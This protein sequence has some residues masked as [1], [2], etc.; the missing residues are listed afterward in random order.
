[1][2]KKNISQ[3]YLVK[4]YFLA[5]PMRDIPHAEIVDWL[6]NE[7][8]LRNDSIFRDPD[9]AIRSLHQSGF[10]IKVTKGVYRYD[11]AFVQ[12]I[13]LEDFSESQKLEILIRDNFRCVICG[14]GREDG[15]ELH[16]DHIKPKALGGLAIVENGQALCGAHNYKK[17]IFGQTETGKKM[18]IRLYELAVFE[19]DDFTA[20]FCAEILSVFE[21]YDVNGHIEWKVK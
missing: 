4:E 12:E 1:M 10:L 19:G 6:T 2:E 8:K 15:V 17:K 9:R 3:I 20:N 18:F 7:W 11:P 13:K 14:K 21:K 5:N 16:I